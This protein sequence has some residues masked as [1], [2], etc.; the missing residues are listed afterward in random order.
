MYRNY[1]LINL[2]TPTN[3]GIVNVPFPHIVHLLS[4]K[5]VIRE[6]KFKLLNETAIKIL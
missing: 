1:V 3:S 6:T 5:Q 2:S 4:I